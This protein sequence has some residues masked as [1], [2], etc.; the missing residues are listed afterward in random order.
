MRKSFFAGLSAIMVLVMLAFAYV[1][2]D[3]ARIGGGRSFGGR[4]SMSQPFTRSL[5]SN[6]SSIGQ[7]AQRPGQQM[8]NAASPAGRGLFGGMG[9]MLGGL[10]A[11]SL[12][13]SLLFG[14]GFQGGGGFLDIILIGGLLYLAYRLFSRR[15]AAT[16]GAGHDN[17]AP[18]GS[19][20]TPTPDTMQQR[21]ATP[22]GTRGGF[23]WNALTTPTSSNQQTFAQDVPN[24][25]AGFDEEEFLRGA[26]AAYARLNSAWDRRDLADI[27]QFSTPAFMK[28]IEQQAEEDKNPGKTEIMLVN[29]SLVQVDTLGAEQIAQVYFNV[30]LREDPTQDAPTEVREIWH[31]TR[32]TN[33]TGTWKLDG[34]QQVD[35]SAYN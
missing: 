25:P 32:P 22:Q 26:K 3:A 1:E 5:P 27:A 23:D 33:D 12:L 20:P 21:T 14:G 24:K 7:Q 17:A 11:G 18:F 9:G 15:R 34:I 30:L 4:P 28:E 29:A 35:N 31:F 2:A 6:P 19:T 13:G 8:A 16:Q 10:L